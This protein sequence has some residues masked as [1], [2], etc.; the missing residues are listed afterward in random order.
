MKPV[1]SWDSSHPCKMGK[2]CKGSVGEE[3]RGWQFFFPKPVDLCRRSLLCNRDFFIIIYYSTIFGA[4]G[5]KMGVSRCTMRPPDPKYH[6]DLR[7]QPSDGLSPKLVD[8]RLQ[9]INHFLVNAAACD[10]LQAFYIPVLWLVV[11]RGTPFSHPSSQHALNPAE[12]PDLGHVG[13]RDGRIWGQQGV[14]PWTKH[15]SQGSVLGSYTRCLQPR[16][17]PSDPITPSGKHKAKPTVPCNQ[18]SPGVF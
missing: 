12:G 8:E 17:V 4:W 10:G 13:K 9:K 18:T 3:S 14:P 7:R 11:Q 6:L 1:G 2:L 15:P 5:Q 16:R